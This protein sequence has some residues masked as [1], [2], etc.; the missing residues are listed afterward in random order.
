MTNDVMQQDD[1][2]YHHCEASCVGLEVVDEL[3]MLEE[4]RDRPQV[5]E[6][7]FIKHE[8]RGLRLCVLLRA[9]SAVSHQLKQLAVRLFGLLS[10]RQH[11]DGAMRIAYGKP[12]VDG[13][14]S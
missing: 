1:S 10:P 2:K 7:E 12:H 6:V 5:V 8:R 14:S 4:V 9:D 3:L 13:K 11:H